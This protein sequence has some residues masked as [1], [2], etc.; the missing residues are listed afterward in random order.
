L[1][2]WILFL[3]AENKA[4]LFNCQKAHFDPTHNVCKEKDLRPSYYNLTDISA[5]K[6]LINTQLGSALEPVVSPLNVA[7]T[8]SY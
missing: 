8:S 4:I 7:V 1:N 2:D 6:N 3:F 5:E